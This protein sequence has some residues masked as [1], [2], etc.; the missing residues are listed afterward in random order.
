VCAEAKPPC[1]F[2]R[3]AQQLFSVTQRQTRRIVSVEEQQVEK[4][5]INR[6]A[7]FTRFL[8][9][10]KF[11]P[12]LK[13][14]EAGDSALEGD[15]F[16]ID[17]ETAVRLFLVSVNQLGIRIVK[18]LFV[19]REQADAFPLAKDKHALAVEFS[20]ESSVRIRES[21]VG[22][23]GQHWRTPGSQLFLP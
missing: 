20:L 19:T 13:S 11:H 6:D 14:R 9:I 10:G 8:R 3:F 18:Q 22:Q 5:M 17:N 2:D 23:C 4:V 21:F 1:Q 12:A 7:T 16:T 15:D